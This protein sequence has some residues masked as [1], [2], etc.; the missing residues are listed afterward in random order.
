MKACRRLTI[1]PAFLLTLFWAGCYTQV[2]S[3][4]EDKFS[5]EYEDESV[6][7]EQETQEETAQVEESSA[8]DPYFD[9]YGYPRNRFYLGYMSP[10]WVTIGWYDP[11]YYRPWYGDPF[12]CW[13]PG[14]AWY[15][16][17]WHSW[18]YSYPPYGW[19]GGHY[20][21][22]RGGGH[23]TPRTIGSTRGS[24]G[25]RGVLGST[26]GG[27]D[28]PSRMAPANQ[29]LPVGMRETPAATPRNEGVTPRPAKP[30]AKKTEE[31]VR[32]KPV[33]TPK[34]KQA[35]PAPRRP[36]VRQQGSPPSPPAYTP[37]SQSGGKRTET[38]PAPA[39]RRPSGN[40]GSGTRESGSSRG[41]GR[42]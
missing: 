34:A 28:A 10:G 27:A 14:P 24:G 21:A 8:Y 39:P 37:G 2:G 1:I 26:R 9:E 19:Y 12:W 5:G 16:P 7:A 20:Y 42:R 25:G 38:A 32:T 4:R 6:A 17:W 31:G 18:S 22:T 40:E 3:V 33:E 11:W 36:S 30:G 23:G 41:G 29:D 15:S 13:N 35:R